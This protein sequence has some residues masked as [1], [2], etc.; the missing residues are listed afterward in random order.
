MWPVRGRSIDPGRF[1]PF[2]PSQLLYEFDGPRTFTYQD[3]EGEL[4]LAHWCDE[5]GLVRRYLVVPFTGHLVQ[6]LLTGELSVRDALN[7]PRAWLLEVDH[8]DH[9]RQAWRVELADLPGDVLPQSGTMLLARLEP[10]LSVRA[11]GDG[12]HEGSIPGSVI[13]TLVE[14][15]QRAIKLLTEYVLELP[16]PAGRPP[17][18]IKRLF[19]L[20]AQRLAFNSFEIAFRSPLAGSPD[21]YADISPE[22]IKVEKEVLDKVGSLLQTG[23]RW[24]TSG[25]PASQ[26]LTVGQAPD[27]SRAILEAIKSITPSSQGAVQAIEIRGSLV[28]QMG[29]PVRLT[30]DT[31][32]YLN[33]TLA[34]LPSFPHAIIQM[35]GRIRELD[36]DRF[37][38][39]LREI[40]GQQPRK[41]LF[42]EDLL[43]DVL[44]AY[45]ENYR[46]LVV[47]IDGGVN[48]AQA[49]LVHRENPGA[50]P[51]TP[52]L[53]SGSAARAD[54]P[55]VE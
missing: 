48:L 43:E 35:I 21:L 18:T 55:A 15:T 36:K 46:V 32:R 29:R 38:F 28:S 53:D 1:Q 19:D 20:P 2:E 8:Q 50:R 23:L 34:Q 24:V 44:Q 22:E 33:A 42:D 7:Q 40:E 13:R 26:A 47:G 39:E 37:S 10:L 51:P 6:Q 12:I 31:R 45:Q 4:F 3:R 16:S 5:D 11:L 25:Q 41:F 52:L 54:S 17:V 30:R 14:G 49:V 27:E 9:V